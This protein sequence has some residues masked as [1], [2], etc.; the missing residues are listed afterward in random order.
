MAQITMPHVD[1][2]R[3]TFIEPAKDMKLNLSAMMSSDTLDEEQLWGVVIACAYFI[4]EPRLRE[5]VIA[6]AKAANLRSELMEDAQAAASIMAMNTIYY[7]FRYLVGK[8]TYKTKSPRLRMS[9]MARPK[10]NKALY[11]L[12]GLA[13][14][15]LAGC[16]DCVKAHEANVLQHGLGEEQVHD[17]VRTAAILQGAAV[18]LRMA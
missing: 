9:W 6:D 17:C 15:V 12:M 8:E 10:T 16:G 18:S 4:D 2:L 3:D 7:R 5:A 11:E 1:A 14:S 13:I